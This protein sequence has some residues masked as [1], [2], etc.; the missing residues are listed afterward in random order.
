MKIFLLEDDDALALGMD[1]SLK[2]EGF[3][4]TRAALIEEGTTLFDKEGFDL[5]IL[6][7]TLPDGNG[8]DFCKYIRQKSDIPIIF[9]TA[10]DDEVNV[11]L[12]LEIGGDDYITK[13]F[14]IREL[15]SRIK[16]ILRRVENKLNVC[17]LLVCEDLELNKKTAKVTKNEKEVFLTAQE[18][19]LLL[20]FMNN[21]ERVLSRD[22][23]LDSISEGTSA[24][25]DSNTLSV[26]I[27]RIREKI[28]KDL[29][30]PE[31]IV[32]V[33]GLGYKWNKT[34]IKR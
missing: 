6:D 29:K 21:Q 20:M 10:L 5:A 24:F 18:Y 34:V 30:N 23:I 2:A 7:I 12:G 13:P 31:F 14:R 4:V 3:S 11:V 28:E 27:K 1:F 22:L 26:Y 8:Y 33:R 9:L 32:T 17:D 15:I 19:K 16:A 25:M